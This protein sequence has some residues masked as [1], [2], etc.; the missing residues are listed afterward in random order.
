MTTT[1]VTYLDCPF[2]Q[3]EFPGLYWL[4]DK[5]TA[6]VYAEVSGIGSARK[7]RVK[8]ITYE[9]RRELLGGIA[10]DARAHLEVR[11]LSYA[12]RERWEGQE[13][14]AHDEESA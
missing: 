4:P 6:D 13:G 1:E 14:H 2:T 9:G 10:L 7:A 11:V 8:N 5:F 12:L 3:A